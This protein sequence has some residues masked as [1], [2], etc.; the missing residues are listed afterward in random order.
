MGLS[1][2]IRAALEFLYR[3]SG[4]YGIAII[5]LTFAIRLVLY[6][7]TWKQTEAMEKMKLL[8]PKLKQLQEKY[9]G[10]QEEY[11]KRVMELYRENKV[12][13]LG[14]CLP[15]LLQLPFIW[16]LFN[17]L[18]TYTFAAERF[19]WLTNLSKPDPF[20]ILPALAGVTT[21]IQ[22]MMVST[23]PSQ[24]MMNL[25]GP[26]F[27]AWIT[28]SLPSGIGLYFLATNV[29]S[30]VQQYITARQLSARRREMAGLAEGQALLDP[31]RKGS[32]PRR[33]RTKGARVDDDSGREDG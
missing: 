32:I 13:P 1:D 11:Q 5:A 2:L 4:S 10:N 15:L 20:Y 28:I 21:Y 26:V 16:A 29:F 31:D 12:N 17:V 9:K 24:R 7:F 25:I 8:Q 19:L 30:I 22:G 33:L 18:R 27:M 6:P 23:D 3:V 14:G